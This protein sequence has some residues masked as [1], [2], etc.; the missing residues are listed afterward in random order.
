MQDGVALRAQGRGDGAAIDVG[1]AV[2]VAAHPGAEAQQARHF[3]GLAEGLDQRG[4]QGFVQHRHH[5]VQDMGDVEADVFALIV[6]IRAQRRGIGGL[7]GSSQG[8]AETGDVGG[9]L[10]G[11]A[12]AV[13]V[14]DQ[15]GD[16]VHELRRQRRYER[17]F[18]HV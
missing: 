8:H 7:P 5:P 3:D 13:Q 4:F 6:H 15:A 10:A 9:A 18:H 11:R 16:H 12:L 17:Q 2:H 1:I 14:V